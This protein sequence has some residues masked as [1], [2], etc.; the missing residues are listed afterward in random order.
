MMMP[1]ALEPLV[2]LVLALLLLVCPTL[3][4]AEEPVLRADVG[5]GVLDQTRDPSNWLPVRIVFAFDNANYTA[6]LQVNPEA[7]NAA[8]REM[9]ELARPRELAPQLR[10]GLAL[11]ADRK[12]SVAPLAAALRDAAP[13]PD[14]ETLAAFT[15]A[16]VQSLPY[17]LDALTTPFNEAWRAPIQTL[18]DTKIDC[19]DSSILYAALLAN[20]GIDV[21]LV[22]VPGH[23][24]TAVAGDFSGDHG[25]MDGKRWYFAETTG[26][27]WPIG[28]LPE[29]Y[30]G[31]E[32]LLLPVGA[33]ADGEPARLTLSRDGA[34]TPRTPGGDDGGPRAIVALT[35]LALL[36]LGGLT[37]WMLRGGTRPQPSPIDDPRYD[38][39]NVGRAEAA[40]LD[41]YEDGAADTGPDIDY[42]RPLPDADDYDGPRYP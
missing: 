19:E 34:S 35:I 2:A 30:A 37:A 15:L 22:L 29:D 28:V 7:R 6:R 10:A 21:A 27:G 16:F 38:Y 4:A 12:G 5:R 11:A 32:A 25:R 24:L 17:A 26:L 20:L 8:E 42:D 40:N 3:Q 9:T 41:D 1:H 33:R 13:A 23:M 36:L 14:A 18:V 39:D 31:D